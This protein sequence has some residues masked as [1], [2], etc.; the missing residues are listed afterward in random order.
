MPRLTDAFL[1]SAAF[2]TRL[3]EADDY[4]DKA[5]LDRWAVRIV[6]VGLVFNVLG[7]K[8]FAQRRSAYTESLPWVFYCNL[9]DAG[10]FSEE[11]EGIIYDETPKYETDEGVME[12]FDT[13]CR[14]AEGEAVPEGLPHIWGEAPEPPKLRVVNGGR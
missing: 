9:I 8:R 6:W 13:L 1:K 4:A 2:K 11:P 12:W 10:L 7:A 3:Q 5:G 14:V